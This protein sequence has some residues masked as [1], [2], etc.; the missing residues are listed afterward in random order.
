MDGRQE[1]LTASATASGRSKW[2]TTVTSTA[3]G[4]GGSAPTGIKVWFT[5]SGKNPKPAEMLMEN[6][7]MWDRWWEN[8]P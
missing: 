6:Y 1:P 5:S 8:K 4:P 2:K 3:A 7:K